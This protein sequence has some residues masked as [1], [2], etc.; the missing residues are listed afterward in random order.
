MVG[1]A[2]VLNIVVVCLVYMVVGPT[3]ILTNKYI[4]NDLSF[5]YPMFLSGLG[6]LTTAIVANIAVHCAGVKLPQSS[7]VTRSFWYTKILPVGAFTAL[8]FT[9]GNAA[10][11]Y[12]TVAFIQMLKAFTPAVVMIVLSVSGVDVPS[13]WVSLYRSC[14]ARWHVARIHAI[15]DF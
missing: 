12:L 13:R 10:Y 3:L 9:F 5:Q 11:M 1:I 2:K 8:C 6:M 7:V 15:A 14:R 4:L